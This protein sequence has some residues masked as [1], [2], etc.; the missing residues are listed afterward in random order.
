MLLRAIHG[1]DPCRDHVAVRDGVRDQ[2]FSRRRRRFRQTSSPAAR[3]EVRRHV[4][5][6]EARAAPTT[7]SIVLPGSAAPCACSAEFSRF[8]DG[9][10]FVFGS[11]NSTIMLKGFP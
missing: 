10:C 5:H 1:D 8:V 4:A 9:A 6:G 3:E 7:E 2:L 11:V